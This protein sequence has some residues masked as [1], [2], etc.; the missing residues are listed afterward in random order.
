M[1]PP[2]LSISMDF[3]NEAG[4]AELHGAA[5][6]GRLLGR[7]HD[8]DR[9]LGVLGPERHQ[10][11]KALNARH[12]EVEQDQVDVALV[13]QG[14][15]EVFHAVR[16]DH[17]GLRHDGSDG[18]PQGSTKQRMVVGDHDRGVL[19]LQPCLPP[20]QSPEPYPERS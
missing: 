1:A 9:K 16:L 4:G 17:A 11:G 6:D 3:G 13:A 2:M 12:R 5:D 19:A 18:L 14:G 10:A 15:V 20:T 8:D 7:G